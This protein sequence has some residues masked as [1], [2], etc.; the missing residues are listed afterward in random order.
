[1]LNNDRG[2]YYDLF[3]GTASDGGLCQ[4]EGMAGCYTA[5]APPKGVL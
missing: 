5:H 3:Y 1:M 4:S 2:V